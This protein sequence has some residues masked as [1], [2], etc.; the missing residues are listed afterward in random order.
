MKVGCA[1]SSLLIHTRFD[2]VTRF[3]RWNKLRGLRVDCVTV[4]IV[5]HNF[6]SSRTFETPTLGTKTTRKRAQATSF[7]Q[8]PLPPSVYLLVQ[9]TND[10]SRDK[11]DPA[12]PLIPQAVFRTAARRVEVSLDPRP[13]HRSIF[14]ATILKN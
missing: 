3:R 4:V 12:F 8:G 6:S 1:L 13:S 2:D 10:V 7:N 14:G 5:N 11:I 9:Y